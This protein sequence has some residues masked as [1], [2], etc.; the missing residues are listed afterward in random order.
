MY[1]VFRIALNDPRAFTFFIPSV[2]FECY[3]TRGITYICLSIEQLMEIYKKTVIG[4]RSL[5]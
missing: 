2:S 4:P 5:T 1:V 3:Y